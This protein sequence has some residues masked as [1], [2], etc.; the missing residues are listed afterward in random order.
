MSAPS[1][2]HTS[3]VAVAPL[4][5]TLS[6]K[7]F[8]TF[9]RFPTHSSTQTEARFQGYLTGTRVPRLLNKRRN[10]V[11]A[12]H[13]K[14]CSALLSLAPSL[15]P[16]RVSKNLHPP[17]GNHPRAIFDRSSLRGY[18]LL[19]FSNVAVKQLPLVEC[20]SKRR[21]ASPVW[22]CLLTLTTRA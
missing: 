10:L 18:Q 22:L 6:L 16:P 11:S 19:Q 9:S 2:T 1:C 8:R 7:P 4:D 3:A 20:D 5:S 15:S 14:P 13:R 21:I 12:A 17:F